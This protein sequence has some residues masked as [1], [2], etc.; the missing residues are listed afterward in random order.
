MQIVDH[1]YN[2]ILDVFRAPGNS[3]CALANAFH[4][5]KITQNEVYIDSIAV[6]GA[7]L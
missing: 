4:Q 7:K 2:R 6:V 3:F 1:W 5:M